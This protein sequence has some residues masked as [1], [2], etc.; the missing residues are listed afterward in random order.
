MR[1]RSRHWQTLLFTALAAGLSDCGDAAGTGGSLIGLY[2]LTRVNNSPLPV[3]YYTD[4]AGAF[5]VIADSGRLDIYSPD[6]LSSTRFVNIVYT[7]G[8]PNPGGQVYELIRYV[9]INDRL[10][11]YHDPTPDTAVITGTTITAHRT[12]PGQDQ[13]Y[14]EYVRQ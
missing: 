9:R 3:T 8:G 7:P 2:R 11:L 1:Q 6:S 13:G 4:P 10:I 14:W 12:A 5:Y